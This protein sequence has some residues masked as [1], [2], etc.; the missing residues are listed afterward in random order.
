MPS[1]ARVEESPPG[2][3]WAAWPGLWG[4]EPGGEG[5]K[6]CILSPV[7]ELAWA[8]CT[9]SSEAGLGARSMVTLVRQL[10]SSGSAHR[11]VRE[12]KGLCKL[13]PHPCRS[14]EDTLSRVWLFSH[15]LKWAFFLSFS[16]GK[17]FPLL[18]VAGERERGGSCVGQWSGGP[19]CKGPG[20]E[21]LTSPGVQLR[22]FLCR[23]LVSWGWG[24][25]ASCPWARLHRLLTWKPP[26]A[27][28]SH[29]SEIQPLADAWLGPQPEPGFSKWGLTWM[30]VRA[31]VFREAPLSAIFNNLS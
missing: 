29:S 17:V 11:P 23:V 1:P 14:P 3:P 5:W 12:V 27:S 25:T 2:S 22:H 24:F 13:K 28:V 16:S 8:S 26:Q 15:S 30:G 4:R 10:V 6:G 21:G 9:A 7:L 20:V 18:S 31:G 19:A